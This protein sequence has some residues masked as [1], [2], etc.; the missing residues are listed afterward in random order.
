MSKE[1]GKEKKLKLMEKFA[2]NLPVF[3]TKLEIS[4]EELANILGITRQTISAIESRQRNMTWSV[5]LAL[6]LIF[7]RNQATKRLLVA[8]EI[9]TP[10]LDE[11][12]N[13]SNSKE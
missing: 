13:I 5:F 1:M 8:L 10:E 9:Y 3:R 12:L 11:F 6:I 7:F 2:E 4:Q